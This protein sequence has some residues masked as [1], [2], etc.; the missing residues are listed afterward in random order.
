[1]Q[2][3]IFDKFLLYMR[4]LQKIVILKISDNSQVKSIGGHCFQVA[5][6]RN[7]YSVHT[8]RNAQQKKSVVH[9]IDTF[10]MKLKFE[11]VQDFKEGMKLYPVSIKKNNVVS[12]LL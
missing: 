12:R 11:F 7:P 4:N 6:I 9:S 3:T 10:S 8:R 2:T 1:M 5:F